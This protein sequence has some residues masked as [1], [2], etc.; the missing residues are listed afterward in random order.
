[1]EHPLLTDRRNR[2]AGDRDQLQ[3]HASQRA[4]LD[5]LH[6]RLAC[7]DR[8]VYGLDGIYGVPETFVVDA[9]DPPAP[10]R[11]AHPPTSWRGRLQPVI[12]AAEWNTPPGR[13]QNV[14]NC[15]SGRFVWGL[16]HPRRGPRPT[17]TR[18]TK[19]PQPCRST[20]DQLQM[21]TTRSR[22]GRRSAAGGQARPSR[23]RPGHPLPAPSVVLIDAPREASLLKLRGVAGAVVHIPA[24]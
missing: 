10:S 2:R 5:E 13:I 8:S 3:T 18:S 12:D 17:S 11:A 16:R 20:T 1:M 4:G 7:A 9:E 15:A 19:E 22:L 6:L 14:L 23:P 21:L 24:R